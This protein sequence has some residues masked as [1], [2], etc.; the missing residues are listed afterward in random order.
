MQKKKYAACAVFVITLFFVLS[1]VL[2]VD[3]W[4]RVGGGGFSG[5]RGSRSFSA[6]SR[7]SPAP[8]QSYGGTSRPAPPPAQ[9]PFQ[10]SGGGFFRNMIGG[11]AGGFLG[12]M[13]FRSL[14][15]GG[16][17]GGGMMGGGGIGFVEILLLAALAFFLYRFIKGR[18]QA[19]QSGSYYQGSET[20]G[21]AYQ[22]PYGSASGYDAAPRET[23]TEQGLRYIRQADPYFD[24]QK[25]RDLCMDNFFQIQGAW[26]GRDVTPVRNLLTPEMYRTLQTDAD[27]MRSEK[28]INRLENIAVRSVEITEAWQEQ[29]QDYITVLFYANLLDYVV[30]ESSGQ[31]VSG[32]KTDPVKF[33]EY[34]TF[35]RNVGNNQWQLSAINQAN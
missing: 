17:L 26:T 19:A 6:P 15:W 12:S 27:R 31:V 14:G 2:E 7:P 4:A 16:G 29:G 9:Q 33:Q 30:D 10:Q 11:M 35:T 24:E 34:W 32:S 21:A 28:K 23:D 13:L 5:S 22:P 18:R 25:F 1:Y 20:T 8:S 3:S